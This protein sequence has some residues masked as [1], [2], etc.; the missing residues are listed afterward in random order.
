[1]FCENESK[2]QDITKNVTLGC[3][4]RDIRIKQEDNVREES[5]AQ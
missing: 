1:M 2:I 5:N 4:Y 3:Y